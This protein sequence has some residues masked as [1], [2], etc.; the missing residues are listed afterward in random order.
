MFVLKLSGIQ[1]YFTIKMFFFSFPFLSC[2]EN[3]I[4][5]KE[6]LEHMTNLKSFDF[7]AIKYILANITPRLLSK[8]KQLHKEYLFRK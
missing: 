7:T 5:I 2:V 6:I 3:T 4:E 8:G 1:I